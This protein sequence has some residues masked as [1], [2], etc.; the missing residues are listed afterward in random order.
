MALRVREDS[1]VT[2]DLGIDLNNCTIHQNGEYR[3]RR[4]EEKGDNFVSVWEETKNG[5][6]GRRAKNG[7]SESF[8]HQILRSLQI[9]KRN[10]CNN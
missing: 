8:D 1:R 3:R 10:I 5:T 9:N 7:T 4:F 2:Y 6:N